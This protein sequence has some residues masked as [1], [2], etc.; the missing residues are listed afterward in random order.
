[1][2]LSTTAALTTLV[3]MVA[4]APLPEPPTEDNLVEAHEEGLLL[5]VP[6]L[7]ADG[8]VGKN[9][10]DLKRD[11]RACVCFFRSFSQFSPFHFLAFPYVPFLC[12]FLSF[13]LSKFLAILLLLLFPSSTTVHSLQLHDVLS[14]RSSSPLRISTPHLIIFSVLIHT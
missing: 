4:A 8:S 5:L 14:M 9:G 11:V 12:S 2:R 13:P 6:T 3:A 7:P 10:K 1:M